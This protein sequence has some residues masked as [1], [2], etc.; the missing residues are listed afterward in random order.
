MNERCSAPNQKSWKYYGEKGI[1]VCARWKKF[2]NF[3]NDMGDRPKDKTLD[4]I[5]NSQGYSK[6]NCRWATAKEQ[7]NNKG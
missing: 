6:E 1:K 7:A 4:R 5:D 2:E 3:F